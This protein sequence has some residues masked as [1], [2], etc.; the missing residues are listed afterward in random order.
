[1][2]RHTADAPGDAVEDYLDRLLVALNGS[3]RQV[4]HNLAEVEAHLHDAVAEGMG[5]GG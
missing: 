2:I 1:M 4:R 3:P 5:A